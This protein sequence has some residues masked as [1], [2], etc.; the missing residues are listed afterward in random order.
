MPNPPARL[1]TPREGIDRRR[2]EMQTL[3][4]ELKE[5]FAEPLLSRFPRILPTKPDSAAR[6][7]LYSAV[8]WFSIWMLLAAV[9]ALKQVYPEFLHQFSFAS[10]GRLRQA[11][12]NVLNWGVL[13]A[14]VMGAAF[15]IV[16][17]MVSRPLWSE[18]I[19]AQLV[20]G[21]SQIVLVGTVLL[22]IGRTQGVDGLELPWPIDLALT[23]VMLG[24]LQIVMATV[25]RRTEKPLNAPAK[26]IIAALHILPITYAVA[27]FGSPFVIG[28]RQTF[29]SGFGS[30]GF[31]LALSLVGVGS[32]L[33]VLSRATGNPLWS[34]RTADWTLYLM[35]FTFPWLGLAQRVLGPT[36]DWTETLGIAMAIAAVIPAIFALV[37]VIGGVRRSPGSKLPADPA[38]AFMLGA[39]IIWSLA[40]AQ[41]ATG[42]LRH[43]AGIVG[44]TWWNEGVRTAFSG[45]F[46][47]W[48]VG[49]TYHLIPRIRGRA[50]RK[51]SLAVAHFWVAI[52]GVTFAWLA[53][54]VAGLVQGYLQV[55]SSSAEAG[56]ALGEGW[57]RIYSS[58]RP[59]L[60]ARLAAGGLV[61]AGVLMFVSNVQQSLAE[62]DDV[63]PD[64]IG[65]VDQT[66]R[67]TV[68][69]RA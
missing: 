49:L 66:V 15:A 36:P 7:A 58:V 1:P 59:M 3:L 14:G 32:T 50:L 22:L 10:Y 53:M 20:V 51:P 12:A 11:E 68:G 43:P 29:F 47:L 60:I 19:G 6:Y 9:V 57:T 46:G 4:H 18:R 17:R 33:F 30:S 26:M 34:G 69:S 25:M 52:V 2:A 39:T 35:L 56:F 45:A 48:L 28:V 16:P 38:L 40:V 27:N 54:S 21:H 55:A 65:P 63:E 5:R 23:A 42:V 41:H 64:V 8:I 44:A 13:F 62:G 37:L 61:F 31:L 24:V 67:E